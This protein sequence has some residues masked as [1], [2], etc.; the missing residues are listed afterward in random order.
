MSQRYVENTP[1]VA[2]LCAVKMDENEK[3]PRVSISSELF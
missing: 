3:S 2:F 1:R